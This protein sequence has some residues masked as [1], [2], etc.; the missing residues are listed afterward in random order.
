MT[1]FQ[2]PAY[3][4]AYR[5]AFGRGKTF[6]RLAVRNGKESGAAWL[7]TRGKSARRLEWWGAGI[8]DIGDVRLSDN[9]VAPLLWTEIND[10]ARKC[11]GAMLAHIESSS[12]LVNL[13]RESGWNVVEAEPC[14]V[15]ILASTWDEYLGS[16]G[17]NRREQ[18]RRYPKRLAKEFEVKYELATTPEQ[19]ITALDDLFRLHGK[20]WRARGQTGVLAT[21]SRQKFHRALCQKL[22]PQ[23]RLRLW[24]LRCNGQASC[25]LLFYLYQDRYSFFIGGF[26]PDLMRWSVGTCLFSHVLQYAISE[27][28]IEMD[29][30]RGQE[31]YKYKLGATDRSYV[32]LQWFAPTARGKLLKRR[33]ALETKAMHKFHLMFSAAHR[34]NKG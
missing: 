12:E 33:V 30:L 29:F 1:I 31:D 18:L 3:L 26:E 16:L 20:R 13:A 22:L 2:T 14:P 6:H 24:T 5:R 17:K 32:S 34:K 10:L 27:G 8:H 19:V 11:D 21:A 9:T 23:N 28:A 4:A 7:Q 25:V 15:A